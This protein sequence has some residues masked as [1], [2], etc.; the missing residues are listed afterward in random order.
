MDGCMIVDPH[1]QVY[2][3]NF[4][5]TPAPIKESCEHGCTDA[6][7]PMRLEHTHPELSCMLDAWSCSSCKRQAGYNFPVKESQEVNGI[8][9]FGLCPQILFF[10]GESDP[11]LP[12]SEGKIVAFSANVIRIT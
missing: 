10:L 9:Q 5:C 2:F 8:R 12:R 3:T 7:V 6:L 11:E 1:P 4:F